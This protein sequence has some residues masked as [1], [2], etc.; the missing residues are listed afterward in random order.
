MATTSEHRSLNC[1]VTDELLV[2]VADKL[3]PHRLQTFATTLI[4][5][6]VDEYQEILKDVGDDP[7]K[8]GIEV[9]FKY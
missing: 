8:Q 2:T 6:S 4:G 3:C 7:G 5:L 1:D 9:S